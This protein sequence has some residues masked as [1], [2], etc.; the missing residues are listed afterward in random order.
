MK[1]Q[2]ICAKNKIKL[3]K[4][5]KTKYN[6]MTEVKEIIISIG[7][8]IDQDLNMFIAK[9]RLEELF[10]NI[11]YSSEM[12]TDPIDMPD[13]DRFL[14]CLAYTRTVHGFKQVRQALKQIERRCGVSYAMKHAGIV[15]M[16]ID[17]LLYGDERLHE[18]NWN[19]PYI[20]QLMKELNKG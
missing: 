19:R 7:T 11:Q 15:K 1:I 16:D 17:I 9:Q 5:D 4:I 2:H 6:K 20:Q 10:H 12:W 14:N 3:T 18:S 8:N 13:S